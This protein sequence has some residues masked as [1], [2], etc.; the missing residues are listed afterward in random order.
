VGFVVDEVALGI[1]FSEYFGFP[2]AQ[3]ALKT[4]LPT[5]L[6]LLGDVTIRSDCTENIVPLMRV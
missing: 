3:T 5:V 4:P 6:L 2:S 1:V